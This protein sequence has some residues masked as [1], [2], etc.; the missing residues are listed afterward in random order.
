MTCEST[1]RARILPFPIDSTNSRDELNLCEFPLAL[2]SDRRS[3]G[4]LE[5]CFTDSLWDEAAG[6][7]IRRSLRISAPPSYG[8]PTAKDEEVL[9]ALIHYTDLVNQF[10]SPTVPFTRYELIRLLGWDDGGKSY[11]RLRESMARWKSITLD[12]RNAW[13]DHRAKCWVS[14]VFSLIDNV[15]LYDAAEQ[16]K[17]GPPSQFD[18]PL[19]SFTWNRI[20]FD[21]MQAKYFKRLDFT[22]Y[23][24]LR[25]STTKRL[26][27]FLDKRFGSG[28]SHWEFD[29]HE[30]AFEHI[31]LSRNYDTGKIKEKLSLA[32]AELEACHFLQP[33]PREERYTKRGNQ[34][35][36]TFAKGTGKPPLTMEL[37]PCLDL[38][39]CEVTQLL[40]NRNISPKTAAKLVATFD[41]HHIRRQLDIFDWILN[42]HPDSLKN[43]AGFFTESI[44]SGFSPPPGYQTPEQREQ[45]K[46]RR[47]RLKST[48]ADR[49][50]E[51]AQ[52]KLALLREREHIAAIR[53]SLTADRLATLEHQAMTAADVAQQKALNTPAL[54]DFQ[55]RLMVDAMLLKQF[56]L[57]MSSDSGN[58]R[59]RPMATA[60]QSR[61]PTT[62]HS[63]SRRR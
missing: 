22:F 28:R 19:S 51:S 41:E 57:A 43:P 60:P 52:E 37:R 11:Q 38:Q 53:Q 33:L 55:L 13:R 63:H 5:L 61:R 23:Q 44:R 34:W 21:S 24:Q 40:L 4:R 7:Q 36:V 31:G 17:R 59:V 8:L 3:A 32:I 30:F 25:T 15:T 56:P 10:S 46:E 20:F 2:L 6:Q 58:S 42:H 27:R 39:P 50:Q 1:L 47:S 29:L 49:E 35:R 26:F 45:A 18:L 54:R 62:P 48:Q 16:Q 9:L 14:E 12:Y